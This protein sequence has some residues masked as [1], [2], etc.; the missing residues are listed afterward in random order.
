M[1]EDLRGY[2]NLGTVGYY[3]ELL[4]LFYNFPDVDWDEDS[5]EA[6]FKGRIV[7]GYDIFDGCLSLMVL[8]GVLEKDI[9]N[10]YRL[11]RKF[12]QK[13]YSQEHC[14]VRVLEALLSKIKD[15]DN[16]YSIFSAEYCSFDMVHNV[17]QVNKSAFGLRFAN[18]R[19]LFLALGF[20]V[21]HPA[22]P[23]RSYAVNKSH[24]NLFDR[25]LTNEIRRHMVS[26]EQL[27]KIRAQQQESGL[28]GEKFVY[29]YEAMRTNRKS[30]IEWIATYDASAGFDIMSFQ[31]H[32]SCSYD[33]FI[34]VK[35]YSGDIPYFYWSRNE[36][37]EAKFRGSQYF[38]YLVNVEEIENPGYK[39]IIICN[40]Y[41]KVL[42]N[43]KWNKVV[44]KYFIR[45]AEA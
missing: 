7:D 45:S 3:W 23:D 44:D 6:R 22:F 34:E 2:E 41:I 12:G 21:P 27:G 26:P 25:Y 32:N 18:V 19:D 31:T 15:D 39:P 11:T 1:L 40:P 4:S 5:I 37:R 30:D 10:T 43:N 28:C 35:A 17:V 8:S 38:L 14:R 16:L 36:V 29:D 9:T 33:R 42:N 24:K 13:L 20:L